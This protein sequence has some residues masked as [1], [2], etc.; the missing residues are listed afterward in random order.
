MNNRIIVA[1]DGSVPAAALTDRSTPIER[2][3]LGGA[4]AMAVE[5]RRRYPQLSCHAQAV[6]G[7]PSEVLIDASATADLMVVG[8]SS[9]GAV[10]AVGDDDPTLEVLTREECLRL[11]ATLPVGRIAVNGVGGPPH[12][13]PVNYVLDGDVIVFRTDPGTKLSAL[14][15]RPVTFQTDLIDLFHRTGWSVSIQG[16]ASDSE[17]PGAASESWAGGIKR[18]VVRV[19]PFHVSGRRIRLPAISADERGYL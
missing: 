3:Q 6:I 7:A 17:D 1:Y 5:L 8:R 16:W 13:V 11:V 19:E 10:E 15:K 2:S 18:H 4:E 12:V 14:R 9:A